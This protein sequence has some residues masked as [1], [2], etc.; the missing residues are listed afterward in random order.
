MDPANV[1]LTILQG[2]TFRWPYYWYSDTEVVVPITAVALSY[3]TIITAVAHALPATSDVPVALLDVPDWLKTVSRIDRTLPDGSTAY[4]TKIGV[5]TFSV[6]VDGTG[7]DAYSGSAA[8]LVYNA[9]M[10]LSTWSARM[11]IRESIDDVDPLVEFSTTDGTITLGADGKVELL[12]SATD[13]DALD[14]SAG[15][16]D[17]ELLDPITGEVTRLASG[18]VK[19]SP[20]VTR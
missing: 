13:T 3:P 1:P 6:K 12:L 9:P 19:L 18:K 17:L 14:F 7:Q 16:Y 15:V 4:A 20:Q 2:A 10:D 8:R 11:A 5:D